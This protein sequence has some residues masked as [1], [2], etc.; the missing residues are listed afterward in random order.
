MTNSRL[1]KHLEQLLERHLCVSLAGVGGFVLE[2]IPAG[3][4]TE[5]MVAYPPS[6]V[7]RYHQ[8]LSHNDG[9]MVESY[10][11]QYG[12]S[13]RR[14]RIMLEE[15]IYSLRQELIR[16]RYAHLEG[17]GM[18]ELSADG[19]I[20][21]ESK[22][23]HSLQS[24]SYGLAMVAL[25]DLLHESGTHRLEGAQDADER[26]Y[27]HLRIPRRA[28][29]YTLS[30]I[31]ALLALVPWGHY[32]ST[33]TDGAE[34]EPAFT[35]SFAPSPQIVDGV[36]ELL[37]KVPAVSV[38]HAGEVAVA[39]EP[40]SSIID[41]TAGR[42]YVIVATERREDRALSHL[43]RIDEDAYPD[44]H[45][46]RGRSVYRVSIAS[47]ASSEEAHTY[48]RTIRPKYQEAWVYKHR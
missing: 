35:A 25:P 46:L 16:Q 21:F 9:L 23:G 33:H 45:V 6:V 43:G 17:V 34:R 2:R 1:S 36:R 13:L 28:A 22:P 3:Y 19:L 29:G 5:R 39:R 10:A 47:F 30:I 7:V 15:D 37:D 14:A 38:E 18:L 41:P 20:S 12:V 32:L 48:L 42:Y 11:R 27:Y 8:S 40:E 24:Y 31:I 26:R 44:V 4:D